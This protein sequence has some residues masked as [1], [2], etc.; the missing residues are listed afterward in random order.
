M[1]FS[2]SKLLTLL[3]GAVACHALGFA[4]SSATQTVTFSVTAI[5]E[6]TVSGN[7]GALTVAIAAAGAAPNA[8][9]DVSTRYAV[10]T[11]GHDR[12]IT[13][14][15]DRAMPAGVTLSAKFSAP[16]GATTAG[17]T[18][19]GTTSSDVVTGISTL[20]ASD[21]EI[22]YEL[23][24]ASGAG[25]VSAETRTVTLTVTAGGM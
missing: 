24:A 8:T 22:V 18:V 16:S 15:L 19:L 5:N 11:N 21:K 1:S 12:K 9:T 4:A 3:A 17:R 7:P 6:L 13:A 2:T 14:A 20:N 10:T 23:S 25:T